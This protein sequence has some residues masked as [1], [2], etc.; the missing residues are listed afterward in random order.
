MGIFGFTRKDPAGI[1]GSTNSKERNVKT[2]IPK[3]PTPVT[4][5]ILQDPEGMEKW[6]KDQLIRFA[7]EER[8]AH[9]DLRREFANAKTEIAKL[10]FKA[11]QAKLKAVG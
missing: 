2:R 11:Q 1:T 3:A 10:K 6:S 4:P 8:G 9:N 5:I 7:K